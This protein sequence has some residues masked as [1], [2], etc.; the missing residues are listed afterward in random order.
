MK[1]KQRYETPE[2]ELLVI[3]NGESFLLDV[4][5]S[6]GNERFKKYEDDYDDDYEG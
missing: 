4:W 1:L 6:D 3:Q 2:A 5:N